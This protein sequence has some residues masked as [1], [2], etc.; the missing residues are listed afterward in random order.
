[1]LMSNEHFDGL[2]WGVMRGHFEAK[3]LLELAA[4]GLH[5]IVLVGPKHSD[6]AALAR[7]L[8]TILPAQTPFLE[9]CP[10]LDSLTRTA[11]LAAGDVLFLEDLEHWEE[12]CLAFLRETY[13]RSPGQFLFAA[14][15]TDCPCGNYNDEI[16][17]CTC[18]IGAIEAHQQHLRQT[19]DACFAIVV[20]L[21]SRNRDL[22][23]RW[24]NEPSC[25]VRERVE[26]ARL[27]QTQRNGEARLNSALSRPEIEECSSLDLPAQK[28]RALAQV[29]ISL[30]AEQECFLLQVAQTAAD[31]ACGYTTVPCVQAN[32]IAEA[33][34]CRPR[35]MRG[36]K[37]K[38]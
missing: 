9:P 13:A 30:S 38:E 26:A 12:P 20:S 19:V 33:I 15:A 2:D 3:R 29:Q 1:M 7:S 35:W 17:D 23:A 22:A 8:C 11:S 27:I 16:Q 18:L 21:S 37:L 32:H 5:S 4:A 25:A 28:L 6:K 14:T 36:T 10:T 31:L 34:C 24:G